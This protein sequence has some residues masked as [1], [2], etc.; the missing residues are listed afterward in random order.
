MVT[1][2]SFVSSSAVCIGSISSTSISDSTD[3]LVSCDSMT[4]SSVG[5]GWSL[6]SCHSSWSCLNSDN[7]WHTFS[8]KLNH[9]KSNAWYAQWTKPSYSNLQLLSH[10]AKNRDARMRIML[11]RSSPWGDAE[12]LRSFA[13]STSCFEAIIADWQ[14]RRRW[15]ALK[16]AFYRL[17]WRT[18]EIVTRS[19]VSFAA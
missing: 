2:T 18:W 19:K 16:Q 12:L 3:A 6:A 15:A 13:F 10:G 5:R 11:N 14:R 9:S 17:R 7:W 1:G 4:T 8:E